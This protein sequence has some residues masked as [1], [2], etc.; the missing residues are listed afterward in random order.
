MGYPE[1]KGIAKMVSDSKGAAH[2]MLFQELAMSCGPACVAMAESL[3]KLKCMVDPEKK[4][5]GISQKYP[6]KWTA[7]GGTMGGNLTDVLNAEGVSTY[8][9]VDIPDPKIYSYLSHYVKDR[10]PTIAHIAWSS[11]GHFTLIRKVYSDGTI[12]CLDPWYGVVEVK[13]K[14][15]PV[16]KPIGAVGKISGWLNITYR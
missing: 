2:Y 10:T 8:K 15:L 14:D 5:R 1:D 6:G 13:K 7:A 16:Y 3:Y 11:G 12:V 9:C 4:A